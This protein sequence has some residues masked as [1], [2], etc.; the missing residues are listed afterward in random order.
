VPTTAAGAIMSDE[1]ERRGAGDNASVSLRFCRAD[2]PLLWSAMRLASVTRMM[3]SDPAG[4]SRL[5]AYA[6]AVAALLPRFVAGNRDA[7][8]AWAQIHEEMAKT[9]SGSARLEETRKWDSRSVRVVVRV[10]ARSWS[11]GRGAFDPATEEDLAEAIGFLREIAPLGC[12]GATEPVAAP[13]GGGRR[14]GLGNRGVRGAPSECPVAVRT[15][16][17]SEAVGPPV[18]GA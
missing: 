11:V 6:D 17:G 12:E 18:A 1:S 7:A 9:P 16:S 15:R 2:L 4:E 10:G 5:R 13:G 8:S 3:C 14:Q